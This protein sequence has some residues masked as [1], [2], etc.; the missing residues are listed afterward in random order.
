VRWA[1]RWKRTAALLLF[2]FS[3]FTLLL[4]SVFKTLLLKS[5]FAGGMA[6]VVERL[7][8]VFFSVL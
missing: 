1:L 5:S 7:P 4:F 8:K 3:S 2:Y 6:Q